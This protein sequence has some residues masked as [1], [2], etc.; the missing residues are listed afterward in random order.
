MP[1]ATDPDAAS[2][3]RGWIPATRDIGL[4]GEEDAHPRPLPQAGGEKDGASIPRPLAGGVRGGHS[5]SGERGLGA[6]IEGG[7]AHPQPLPQAGGRK[8]VANAPAQHNAFTSPRIACFLEH[9]S[10]EGNVRAAAQAAGVSAQTAYVRRRRDPVFAGLWDAALIV[11][12]E[13]AEQ[14]LAARA[15]HGTVETIWFRGEAVGERRRF[16]ARLLLAHLARLDTR[17]ARASAQV[18]ASLATFDDTL[19]AL[20]A[21]EDLH[22]AAQWPDPVRDAFLADRAVQARHDFNRVNPE[23]EDT[24]DDAAWDDW[25]A[26]LEEAEAEARDNAEAE[27][28]A[29]VAERDAWLDDALEI[30]AEPED[31]PSAPVSPTPLVPSPQSPFM[32]SEVETPLPPQD[33]VNP[34]NLAGLA[35]HQ[36]PSPPRGCRLAPTSESRSASRQAE[37]DR[38]MKRMT[39]IAALAATALSTPALAAPVT[40]TAT[41]T[42][43]AETGGGDADGVGGFKVEAD[44]DSGDFCF[45]LWAD[46]T[47]KPTMAHVHEGAA[48]ADGKPVATLEITGKDSDA[49]IAM[50]PA[51]IKALVAN[52]AGYY[53]NVHTA[54]FPKGAVRGQLEKK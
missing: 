24:S 22:G 15:I 17:A 33:S 49:C 47:T 51:L 30:K 35:R 29:H 21:G 12:R 14:V 44:E 40:F 16:D 13:A 19:A 9:L 39:L 52:P 41:L 1:H 46:K 42:G 26:A 3:G 5:P 27:W 2:F 18:H 28:T 36:F 10:R 45:T 6:L 34:V 32:S 50:E 8:D 20:V 37:G 25:E 53:V 4:P 48:G 54:D 31:L 7:E 11:A 38:T 23:P 43:A